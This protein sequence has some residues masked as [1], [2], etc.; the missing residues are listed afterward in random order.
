[1]QY[2]NVKSIGIVGLQLSGYAAAEAILIHLSDR[3][4][5]TLKL[6][7]FDD[8]INEDYLNKLRDKSANVE[9]YTLA[10]V[11]KL[12]EQQLLI[13]SPGIPLAHPSLQAAQS[14]GV[15]I[16]GD[17]ELFTYFKKNRKKLESTPI[18]GITGSNGKTTVTHLTTAIFKDLGYEAVM[19]GNVGVPIMSTLNNDKVDV[20][21]VEL[22]SF[23]LETIESLELDAAT[24]LNISED[25][26]DRYEN[27]Q[28]YI[29]AKHIIYD[30]AKTI[31]FNA[32]DNLTLPLYNNNTS[33]PCVSFG[34]YSNQCE[35]RYNDAEKTI[36]FP[37]YNRNNIPVV[38]SVKVSEFKLRGRHNYENILASI[39]LVHRIVKP[40]QEIN[41]CIIKTIKNF[42]GLEHR[43]QTVHVSENNVTFIN[44]SKATNVGSVISAITSTDLK[45]KANLYLLLGGDGKGQDFTLLSQYVAHENIK[46]ICY[47]R[48]AEKVAECSNRAVVLPGATLQA[49]LE[50]IQPQLKK[51]DVVLLSPGCAS[52]DQFKNFE[53]RGRVFA[54]L[55]KKYSFPS[56]LNKGVYRIFGGIGSMIHRLMYFE[57]GKASTREN[58]VSTNLY[59]KYLLALIFTLF[60]FG[61]I[62]VF[63]SSVYLNLKQVGSVFNFKQI[64]PMMLGVGAFIFALL[65]PS[66]EWSNKVLYLLII[67]IASLILVIVIGHNIAGG[68]R[69][70]RFLGFTFQPAELAK[71]VN[72]IYLAHFIHNVSK[73]DS[74]G[75]KK[76]AYFAIY[77]LVIVVLLFMQPDVGTMLMITITS[78]VIVL[79]VVQGKERK[80]YVF[81]VVLIFFAL[82]LLSVTVFTLLQSD[83]S[84][85][86][87]RLQGFIFPYEDP[88]GKSYQIINSISAF[89]NGDYT[90]VGLGSSVFK[91]GFLTE[92]NTDYILAIIGEEFGYIGVLFVVV[93]VLLLTLRNLK[94]S[95]ET[96]YKYHKPFQS[97]LVLGFTLW[98]D[99]QSIYSFGMTASFLPTDGATFPL[100]SYGG[101]SYLVTFIAYGIIMRIDHENRVESLF[102]KPPENKTVIVVNTKGKK[103]RDKSKSWWHKYLSTPKQDKTA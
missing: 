86:Q 41:D 101:S 35:Y 21:V 18:V 25:H 51:N 58:T 36:N 48:D 53:E 32:D 80:D 72:F 42:A 26:L 93:M 67:T 98:I 76:F 8:R 91:T 81:L 62:S 28:G 85:L 23:Q 1:M 19:C 65:I 77:Y 27:Y 44:D 34:S 64:F 3:A 89:S 95:H 29:Y 56:S 40:T 92:A 70:I 55:A 83:G 71:L 100:L 14:A 102:G 79:L 57:I 54:E 2:D 63:S 31:V 99:Y 84:Y 78:G 11:D 88:Y 87:R 103:I 75:F 73:T 37:E 52:Y 43:Y 38:R 5:V 12:K 68:Q 15:K 39:A 74:F 16:I 7:V 9:S 4:D 97:I 60:T 82:L 94:I 96:M 33:K 10:A 66:I 90:G 45:P 30:L 17:I 46:V 59:D 69:W 47:G 22:S 61:L 24:I 50:H 49:V 6:T 13:V 20:F